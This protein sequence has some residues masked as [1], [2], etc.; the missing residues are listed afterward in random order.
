MR[1]LIINGGNINYDFASVYIKN[2]KFD[3]IIAVDGG[4]TFANNQGIIPD[5]IIGDF[6]TVEPTLL[7]Q[8][9]S[10]SEI[11]RFNPQKDNTD[12]EI[13]ISHACSI[14]SR[15]IVII[16]A[17]GKR[18]DHTL[19]NIQTLVTPL[20]KGIDAYIIDEYNKIYLVD[21]V[22]MISKNEAYGKYVSLIPLTTKVKGLTLSGFKYPLQ[23]YTYNIGITLGVSNELK[24]ENGIIKLSDGILIVIESND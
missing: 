9:S 16:G 17:T 13:A 15:E 2:N 8:Y 14:N 1:T 18:M 23:K 21:S 10:K 4:L 7:E 19:A 6:D 5:Y 12:S 24:D 20:K 3:K 11:I 22:K